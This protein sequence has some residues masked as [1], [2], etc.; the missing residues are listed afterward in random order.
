MKQ[1]WSVGQISPESLCF[2]GNAV[3]KNVRRF[4]IENKKEDYRKCDQNLSCV[5]I[6]RTLK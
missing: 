1:S 5:E 6:S 2:T 4:F 3:S